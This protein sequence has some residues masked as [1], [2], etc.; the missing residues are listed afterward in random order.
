M[1]FAVDSRGAVHWYFP[2]WTD[3]KENPLAM[4][5]AHGDSLQK[6]PDAIRHPLV[7]GK[8][9]VY[10]LFTDHALTVREVEA[11]LGAGN[12]DRAK[13]GLSD[14][15]VVWSRNLEVAP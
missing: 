10:G 5:I 12:L 14:S 9:R 2:A 15:D 1:V 7:P 6:L 8:L 13:L 4:E 3:A 11:G